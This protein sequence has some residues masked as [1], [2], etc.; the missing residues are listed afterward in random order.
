MVD[1]LNELTKLEDHP[2]FA[3]DNFMESLSYF[4]NYVKFILNLEKAV[5]IAKVRFLPSFLGINTAG[6]IGANVP[7]EVNEMRYLK[8]RATG[9]NVEELDKIE[10]HLVDLCDDIRYE[11]DI[12]IFILK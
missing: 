11:E 2:E 4:G 9:L 1:P 3:R 6:K 10:E 8:I 7:P 12:V 5:D